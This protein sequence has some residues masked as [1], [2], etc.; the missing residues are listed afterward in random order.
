MTTETKHTPGKW[1]ANLV[2]V[3]NQPNRYQVNHGSYHGDCI[4]DC[5]E[6][7]SETKANARL[8]SAAPELKHVAE[9][10]LEIFRAMADPEHC[11]HEAVKNAKRELW[12][13]WQD[14][15]KNALQKAKAEG[16]TP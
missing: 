16:K 8:I 10:V 4:A 11:M 9:V 3:N 6:A 15:A 1:T 13:E 12:I 14:M 5:G 2:Y 7:T